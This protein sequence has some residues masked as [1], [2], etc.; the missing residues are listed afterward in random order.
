MKEINI[1][2]VRRKM[3]AEWKEKNDI[4][5]ATGIKI[6]AAQ[7]TILLESKNNKDYVPTMS[8][9]NRLSEEHKKLHTNYTKTLA[10]M[11][12]LRST[13][14]KLIVAVNEMDDELKRKVDLRED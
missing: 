4:K 9:F 7:D 11:K 13:I 10:E 2:E 12:V 6:T 14:D 3:Y 8:A 1:S 5:E